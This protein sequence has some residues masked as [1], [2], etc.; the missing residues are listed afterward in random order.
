MGAQTTTTWTCDRCGIDRLLADILAEHKGC[1]D[2]AAGVD[3]NGPRLSAPRRWHYGPG[4]RVFADNRRRPRCDG[5][6]GGDRG[7]MSR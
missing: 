4:G 3:H 5:Y 7:G 2:C 1:R 6:A